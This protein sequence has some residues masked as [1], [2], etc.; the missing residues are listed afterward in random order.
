MSIAQLIKGQ[1]LISSELG[2]VSHTIKL[3]RMSHDPS[4]INF[5]IWPCNSK[6]LHGEKFEGRSGGCNEDWEQAIM[7]TVGETIERYTPIFFP[8]NEGIVSSYKNLDKPAVHPQEYAFFHDEQYKFYKERNFNITKFDENTEVT[9]C[10][11]IDLVDQKEVYCPAQC[12]YMPFTRDKHF[13]TAGNSTGLAA[14]TN[15]Y[16]AVLNALYECVERDSFVITWTNNIVPPKVKISKEIKD[17]LNERFPASFKWHFFD[18]TYDLELPSIFA[19]CEGV[20][21]YGNF[22][23]VGS[24]T[25]GTLAEAMKRVIREIGQTAPYFRW[26]IGERNG[27]VPDEDYH[28][29]IN[30]VDHSIYYHMRPEKKVVFNKWLEKEPDKDVDMYEVDNRTETEK[31]KDALRVFKRH[32]Y[33]VLLK[34][35]TTVDARQLGFYSVKVYIPQLIQM[36]GGYSVYFWGGKRLYEVPEKMGYGKA[37]YSTIN[38]MPHPFP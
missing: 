30:F 25:R 27:Q 14:H 1:K 5:G 9:W 17:Y 38:K 6:Y 35:L 26:L 2:I 28:K 8:E 31:I 18:V 21:D 10:P 7:A 4:M 13:I 15:Y 20:S 22:I 32:N 12:I 24:A 3:P 11:T 29:I 34:D 23:T 19:I 36:A 16:K 33:N 37:D